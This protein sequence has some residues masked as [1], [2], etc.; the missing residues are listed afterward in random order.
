LAVVTLANERLRVAM[1]AAGLA[2]DDVAAKVEVDPKTV[3]RWITTGRVP[4]RSH[5]RLTAMLLGRD[6]AYLWPDIIDDA[7][8]LRASEAE[9]V[10][11]YPSRA[12]VPDALWRSLLDGTAEAVE[13]LVY[14]GQFLVDAYPDLPGLLAEK[15]RGGTQVRMLL[16]DPDCEA[17]RRRGE[18]EGIGADLAARIRLSL[19]G[20]RPLLSAPGVEIRL[21]DSTLYCSTYRFDDDI[22]VN[23][24]VLGAPAANAPV[25][26]L[27]R[28]PGG[29]LFKQYV[30]AFDRT[31][32]ATTPATQEASRSTM[33]G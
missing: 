11:F 15:A 27:R 32:Q 7:Q 2:L 19:A 12:A 18:E 25:L 23:T 22:F 17:V 10:R 14:A 3:E 26:H 24:H 6:E 28:M 13:V 31:W 21:H 33:A 4:H 5:R 29:R 1:S 9:L 20:L 30:G 16:G 8:S